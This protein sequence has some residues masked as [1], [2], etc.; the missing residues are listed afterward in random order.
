MESRQNYRPD[1]RVHTLGWSGFKVE[2]HVFTRRVTG[3]CDCSSS[4]AKR[5]AETL[6]YIYIPRQV[7][8]SSVF[9]K[10][11]TNYI[12]A[13]SSPNINLKLHVWRLE[14]ESRGDMSL[15]IFHAPRSERP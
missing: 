14:Y 11:P 12:H 7:A 5:Q 1:T 3:K 10:S 8:K 15:L 6:A 13:A 9:S 2:T 4:N